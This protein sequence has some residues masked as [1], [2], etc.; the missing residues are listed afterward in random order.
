MMR[1]RGIEETRFHPTAPASIAVPRLVSLLR[2]SYRNCCIAPGTG[3]FDGGME[4]VCAIT[5]RILA[6]GRTA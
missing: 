4:E 6:A 2:H 3:F 1:S 5:I